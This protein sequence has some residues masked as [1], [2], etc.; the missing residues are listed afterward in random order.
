MSKLLTAPEICRNQSEPNSLTRV[1]LRCFYYESEVK[2]GIGRH[3]VLNRGSKLAES[4]TLF[5]SKRG[6]KQLQFEMVQ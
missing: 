4:P 2:D 3:L 6:K 5:S 1:D